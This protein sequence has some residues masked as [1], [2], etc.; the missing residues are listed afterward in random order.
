MKKLVLSLCFVAIGTASTFAYSF[1]D[2]TITVKDNVTG[3]SYTITVHG[4]SC[5]ELIKEIIK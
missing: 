4:K 2:C 3:K 5:S 1:A